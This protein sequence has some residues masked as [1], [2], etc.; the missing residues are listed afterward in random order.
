MEIKAK[1]K[2]WKGLII[3][4]FKNSETTQYYYGSLVYIMFTGILINAF[5]SFYFN[6]GFT[7]EGIVGSGGV[8]FL[9]RYEVIEFMRDIRRKGKI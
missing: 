7:L 3:S 2:K 1:L 5:T 8:C 6:F 4:E 9:L